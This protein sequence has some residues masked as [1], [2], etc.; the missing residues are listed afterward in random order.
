[1]AVV[2]GDFNL[3]GV[4]W[5]TME[6]LPYGCDEV[7]M[8]S[9]LT[10]L[11]KFPTMVSLTAPNIND[12]IFS[13]QPQYVLSIEPAPPFMGSIHKAI[14]FE[15]YI[16]SNQYTPGPITDNGPLLDYHKGNYSEM[17]ADLSRCN[18]D[19]LREVSDLNEAYNLFCNKV[20]EIVSSHCPVIKSLKHRRR[21]FPLGMKALYKK[22][23][24]MYRNIKTPQDS[25]NYKYFAKL[26]ANKVR[27]YYDE[28]DRKAVESSDNFY[29]YLKSKM[30][31][32]DDIISIE[33]SPGVLTL[34]KK[35][36]VELFADQ[37]ASVYRAPSIPAVPVDGGSQHPDDSRDGFLHEFVIT[38]EMVLRELK[39]LPLKGTRSADN[40]PPIVL[41]QCAES[42][43]K[44]IT[45]LLKIS[46]STG[47]IPDLWR[48]I[49]VQPV[50]KKGSKKLAKNY[51]PIGLTC[52][53]S[54]ICERIIKP[55]IIEH[56]AAQGFV[57]TN[58][59]GFRAGRSTI[60]SLL[61]TQHYWKRLLQTYEEVFVLYLDFSKAFDV[62]D[63]SILK[64]KLKR[65]G[66]GGCALEW[67]C[68]YLHQ[69]TMSVIL[70]TEE[71]SIM[72]VHS[73][74]IQGSAAGPALFSFFACDLPNC[75]N[76]PDTV[77]LFADDVKLSTIAK[78]DLQE[79]SQ[80]VVLWSKNNN[81][82]LAPDKSI[83]IK[84]R[85]RRTKVMTETICIDGVEIHSTNVVKD[86]GILVSDD[87]ECSVHIKDMISRAF[88]IANLV[89]R[90]LKTKK[91]D[92]FKKAF[93][94]LVL[95][96]LEYGSVVW[97]PRYVRDVNR[98]E[99]V[100]RRFTKRAQ[101]KCG[102]K[103]ESY[104]NRLKRWNIPTLE[105]RR[106]LID[107]TWVYK[108]VYGHVDLPRDS[109]FR[110]HQTSN[111]IKIFPLPLSSKSRNNTQTNTIADRTYQC[112]NS[113]P[114]LIR[115][116][117]SV[118]SFKYSLK[119]IDLNHLTTSIITW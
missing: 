53:L 37:F 27:N 18:W 51:R 21:K 9:S 68:D 50:H 116:A 48:H 41:N 78:K 107:L 79:E 118:L 32:K 112:W 87:L 15:L 111:E 45:T 92:I 19:G 12:L 16:D 93:Y 40:I 95:P 109:F 6:G 62:V 52:I 26:C 5:S 60:T 91:I 54:K 82:P 117:P 28:I 59:H 13:N 102:L 96:I 22:K 36:I 98:V 3:P 43:V 77:N 89:L 66:V 7:I 94:S 14:G 83:F 97:C 74:V 39:H 76:D 20:K 33:K 73:G 58:Q 110:I 69:R 103:N 71:S 1:V 57:S 104:R 35:E 100:Q 4:N 10:Q 55:Q 81:L 44:P 63:H 31:Q 64:H 2:L 88:R 34:D 101:L 42:L 49:L 105:L 85:R 84:I 106:L 11:V 25:S 8:E 61:Q 80:R 113:L 24:T 56:L 75:L 17:N 86:L 29:R 47:K 65:A 70:G 67:L 38:E 90:I 72:M 46:L 119:K 108:I 115:N 30:K 99:Q 23:R 114:L